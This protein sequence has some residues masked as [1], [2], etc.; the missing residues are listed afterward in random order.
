MGT[1]VLERGTKVHLP[2]QLQLPSSR[3]L[4]PPSPRPTPF[5]TIFMRWEEQCALANDLAAQP[6]GSDYGRIERHTP[7]NGDALY[8]CSPP[9]QRTASELHGRRWTTRSP[10]SAERPSLSR[11]VKSARAE[12][13]ALQVTRVYGWPQALQLSTPGAQE[14]K[15]ARDTIK[16]LKAQLGMPALPENAAVPPGAKNVRPILRRWR[17]SCASLKRSASDDTTDKPFK[18]ENDPTR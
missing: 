8:A 4:P 13:E 17:V 15:Q 7:K 9:S 6:P 10:R 1:Y 16:H 11:Q 5:G 3:P 14:L 12:L 2:A 18:E